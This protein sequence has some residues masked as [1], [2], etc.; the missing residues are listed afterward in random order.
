MSLALIWVVLWAPD[1]SS[2]LD[3]L[4]GQTVTVAADGSYEIDDVAGEG[5]PIVGV[6]ERRG[7]ALWVGGHRLTGPLAVPR[8]AGPGYKVWL[9][10]EVRGDTLAV[11]RIGVL[12][13]PTHTSTE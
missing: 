8:I 4:V 3:R 5:K 13:R 7:G 6:V 11:R 9:L 2:E 12:L 1:L 10:G